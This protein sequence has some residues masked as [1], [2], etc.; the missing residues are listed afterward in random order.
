M[1]ELVKQIL[2]WIFG[3]G[4]M[5]SLF[6]IYQ[7]TKRKN[8]I[9]AKL[10]ADV[11]WVGHYLCLGGIA[12]M[13]P[14]F[15]GIFRELIFIRREKDKWAN[16]IIWPIIFII[17]G[18]I[19]GISTFK[20]A[21]NILPIAASSF[22]TI[23]L[24]LKN[25]RFTKIL[26]IPIAISFLIYD[27]FVFSYIGIINETLSICSIIISFYKE[28]KSKMQNSIFT[29]D[30]TTDKLK[31]V[32]E[33]IAVK[34]FFAKIEADRALNSADNAVKFSQEVNNRRFA[35][36]E[37]EKDQMCHVSTFIKTNG[38]IYVSYYAN[39]SNGAE[40]PNF[41][42]ARL[43]YC[44]E[45][46]PDDIKII[47]IQAAQ[48][49]LED[50]KVVGIYDTIIMK[51][52]DEPNNI[53]VLWTANID[54]NYYR[55]YRIFNTKTESLGKIGI[56]RFKV[57]NVT[58]DFCFSG[59]Q[60][61]LAANGIGFKEFFA[62]IGIMQKQSWREENGEMYCYSGAYSGNFTCIIK[63]KDLITWEYVAQPNEGA[64]ETGFDNE[65]KWENA[66]Y[67]LNDKVYYFV[68]QWDP[69]F[70][71]DGSLREGSSYG[72]LTRFDLMTKEWDRPVLVGDCQSRSDF[73][74]YK[75]NLYLFYAPTDREHIGILKINTDDLSKSTIVLQADMKG[76][77]FYP[78]VQYFDD[79]QLAIS[80]TVNRQH[81]R[82]ARFN[83][84]NYL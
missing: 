34:D 41:Q 21:F 61:A 71:E 78:F 39:T 80:Y 33:R 24:W 10:C 19:L 84:D 7:Q 64:N 55:L 6:T 30:I 52:D 73:I 25:P 28:R 48:D 26:S 13:I 31:K 81:I 1:V 29:P 82:L 46:R 12:G 56:N 32:Y 44:P 36:F 49:T 68:R 8:L 67:V 76:S 59:M 27:V 77:C 74:I 16:K 54:G 51:R 9:T 43:A 14:N 45:N 2:V 58:N 70:N 3:A 66:V 53:Y 40:D 83:L 11:F 57:G 35:D 50:K 23:S 18:W 42:V 75:D 62:D 17:L 22:V 63:S 15:L 72:I 38:N 69:V 5:I 37:S 47:D 20:N 4:A 79:T 60:N 65:T